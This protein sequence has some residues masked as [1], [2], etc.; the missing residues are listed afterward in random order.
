MRY[1][2]QIF[3][4][5]FKKLKE[6]DQKFKSNFDYRFIKEISILIIDLYLNHRVVR[7]IFWIYFIIEYFEIETDIW[8]MFLYYYY[9]MCI[10][11]WL[12]YEIIWNLFYFKTCL[13]IQF[14]LV[15]ET[16]FFIKYLWWCLFFHPHLYA[17]T[18]GIIIGFVVS[19]GIF[20]KF[21]KVPFRYQK[22][23][24]L[25]VEKALKR[26]KKWDKQMWKSSEMWRIE[27]YYNN[28]M[29]WAF[30]NNYWTLK[31]DYNKLNKVYLNTVIELNRAKRQI[32]RNRQDEYFD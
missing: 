19:H 24:V 16:V 22:L 23:W 32:V 20:V 28:V 8:S 30:R 14:I 26:R 7:R 21:Y 9:V 29:L 1:E 13:Y 3:D 31:K 15:V 27:W 12:L 4:V 11:Y 2:R 5:L 10:N 17:I 6:I 18:F 25:N